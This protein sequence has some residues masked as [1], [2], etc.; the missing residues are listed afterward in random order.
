MRT[1]RVAVIGRTGRGNYGHGLDV[2]W[3]LLPNVT[4]AAMA[5]ENPQGLAAAGKRLGVKALYADYARMLREERPD[6]VSVAPRWA[7]CH[8]DMV[9][10]AAEARASIYLEK[11]MSRTPEEADRMIA[12]CDRAGVKLAVAHQMRVCPTLDYARQKV[13]EGAIGQLQELRGRGKEDKRAGGEDLMVLGTH[14]MD[15][16]RQFAGDPEWAAGRVTAAGR[17]IARRDVMEGREGLGF[18][19]GD[20]VAGTF[21]FRNGVTGYFGSKRSEDISG[22][23]FGLDLYGSRGIM[24]IRAGFEPEVSLCAS[25]RWNN[26]PWTRLELPGNPP[27]R[28]MHAANRAVVADLLEAIENGREPRSSGRDARWTIEMCLALYHSQLSGGR[29]YFP[30]RKRAHPLG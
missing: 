15:L 20:A 9:L 8:C 16:M 6:I 4:V 11:P 17:D 24:S 2:V 22:A 29:V 25:P 3:K 28:D 26:A 18:I 5:D 21:A 30:L 14:V 19:A 1:W 13:A 7:D 27:R 10:A 12:A 23:R